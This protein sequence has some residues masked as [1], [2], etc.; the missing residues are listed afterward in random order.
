MT[1]KQ[2]RHSSYEINYHFVW[3]PKYRRKVLTPDIANRLTELVIEKTNELGGEV[4]NLT[5][6][7]DQ[8]H[9]FCNFPPTIAPHQI[10]HRLKGYSAHE[11]RKEFP[12]LR[13]RLPN[14]WTRSYYVGTAGVVSANTI[15]KYIEAQKGK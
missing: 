5:V 3:V 12:H 14:M 15:Q 6:Q 10:M 7:V 11:L 13:S 1:I 8:V 9:L 2:T 4:L